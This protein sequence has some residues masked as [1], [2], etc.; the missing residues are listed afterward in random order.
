MAE[1]SDAWMIK[2]IADATIKS[3][4]DRGPSLARWT[5]R[6]YRI[7]LEGAFPDGRRVREQLAGLRSEDPNLILARTPQEPPFVVFGAQWRHVIE[8]FNTEDLPAAILQLYRHDLYSNRL[9]RTTA[10]QNATRALT[11]LASGLTARLSSPAIETIVANVPIADIA[12]NRAEALSQ[13]DDLIGRWYEAAQDPQ[14]REALTLGMASNPT[15]PRMGRAADL[16]HHFRD[17]GFRPVDDNVLAR[18]SAR[19]AAVA[20]TYLSIGISEEPREEADAAPERL[21]RGRFYWLWITLGPPVSGGVG[22]EVQAIRPEALAGAD[23][24]VVALFADGGL[25]LSPDPPK[26]TFRSDGLSHFVPVAVDLPQL[27]SG[28]DGDRAWI[29][30]QTPEHAGT[31]YVRCGVFVRGVLVHVETLTV[32]VGSSPNSCEHRTTFRTLNES[33]SNQLDLLEAPTLTLYA[34]QSDSNID[35]SFY[36]PGLQEPLMA[37][38]SVKADDALAQLRFVRSLLSKISYDSPEPYRDQD[39]LYKWSPGKA[40]FTSN[41]TSLDIRAVA[42]RGRITWNALRATLEHRQSELDKLQD[43]MRRPGT[44]EI[45]LKRDARYVLPAQVLYDHPLDTTVSPAILELCEQ[46]GRWLDQPEGEL[47]CL[48]KGCSQ[49]DD[50]RRV[51]LS[52]FWGFRHAVSTRLSVETDCDPW[53]ITELAQHDQ[54]TLDHAISTEGD[55]QG[56]WP[57]HSGELKKN[58]RLRE[59]TIGPDDGSV[60]WV[61]ALATGQ[62]P[63]HLLYFLTHME[64]GKEGQIISFNRQ[65]GPKLDTSAII[66]ARLQLCGNRPLVFLNGCESAGQDPLTLLSLIN[67]FLERGA[68][69]AIGTEITVF[70]DMATRFAEAFVAAF[71]H[72]PLGEAMRLARWDLLRKGSPLGLVYLSFGLVNLHIPLVQAGSADQVQRDELPDRTRAV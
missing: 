32:A 37:Q 51:C 58:A 13:Y 21:D 25:A 63:G 16:T 17:F 54:L 42:Q 43:L 44:V 4:N 31:W 39:S 53:P 28:L 65:S 61:K 68:S 49:F 55:I 9:A 67:N 3:L 14:Q 62:P 2:T 59:I 26:I 66:D 52:G 57:R 19:R 60:A 10:F 15:L 64:I 46:S 5:G 36:A 6:I 29:R 30:L 70:L 22:T 11:E 47:A 18:A 34:N 72:V 40:R 27:P 33:G 1:S 24:V 69:G 35:L 50:R 20:A 48:E 41:T 8:Q 7:G 45:V 71:N 12:F 56:D 38:G 23:E